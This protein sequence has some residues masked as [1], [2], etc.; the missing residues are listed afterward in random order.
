MLKIPP[1][2]S[3]V[4]QIASFV[5]LWVGL[6]RLLFDPVIAML[7]EREARTAGRARAAAEIR[8]AAERDAADYE[9]R[10]QAVRVALLGESE[11]T[12]AATRREESQILAAAREQASVQLMQLRES[13]RRQSEAAQ[14]ALRTE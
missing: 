13:L 2:F 6:K 12:R 5:V 8:A 4:I 14:P 11:V 7:E 1:D 3:F 9:R 10:L